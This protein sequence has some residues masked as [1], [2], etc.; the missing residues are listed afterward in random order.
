MCHLEAVPKPLYFSNSLC[1]KLRKYPPKSVI[2]FY[3][4]Q[5]WTL[6]CLGNHH[7]KWRTVSLSCS[8]HRKK[9]T[10]FYRKLL[11]TDGCWG[12]KSPSF[13]GM[14]PPKGYP[15]SS[16]WSYTHSWIGRLC[17]GGFNK[18]STWNLEVKWSKGRG[19]MRGDV[20][21]GWIWSKH[22]IQCMYDI[23]NQ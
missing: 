9:E 16:W 8:A 2:V 12:G 1:W 22:N 20:I 5:I 13:S 6:E 14:W 7:V 10:S 21:E 18:K 15:Y 17:S 19:E 4:D 11:A 23:L 3:F